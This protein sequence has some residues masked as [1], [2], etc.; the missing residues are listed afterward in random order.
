MPE[1]KR[2]LRS[3]DFRMEKMDNELLL[4]NHVTNRILHLNETASLIWQLC[5]GSR[6]LD[7]IA[8]LLDSA[9]PEAAGSMATDVAE[10][11]NMLVSNGAVAM[12]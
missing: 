5:E 8:D 9:Y 2:P 10:T 1:A 7:E 11:I 6:T 12:V 4:F 3:S